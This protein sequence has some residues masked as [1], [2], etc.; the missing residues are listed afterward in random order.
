[1]ATENMKYHQ[2]YK[3]ATKKKNNLKNRLQYQKN[4]KKPGRLTHSVPFVEDGGR[5]RGYQLI[6]SI[7]KCSSV[8]CY[9]QFLCFYTFKG[10]Q[11]DNYGLLFCRCDWD[12]E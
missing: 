6:N 5:D 7:T 4:L 2:V 11:N 3:K 10:W 8:C 12:S 9:C 1:M